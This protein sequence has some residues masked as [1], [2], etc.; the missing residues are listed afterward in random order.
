VLRYVLWRFAAMVPTLLIIS[1]LVFTIIEMPPGDYFES[2]ISELR[3]AGEGVDQEQIDILRQQ[4]GFDQPPVLRYF[5]WVVGM[6]QGDFGYSF[7]YQLPVSE[8]VGDRMWLTILVSFVTIIFTWLIA[9]PIGM[10][11]ATHQYSWGD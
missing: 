10:Y 8:V 3:A 5:H 1:A 2:Y 6:L 7:E 11:S 4:Y 9:F